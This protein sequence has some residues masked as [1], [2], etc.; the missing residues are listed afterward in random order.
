[1]ARRPLRAVLLNYL[2]PEAN[3]IFT[4]CPITKPYFCSM[5]FPCLWKNHKRATPPPVFALMLLVLPWYSWCYSFLYDADETFD[6]SRSEHAIIGYTDD[7]SMF[8][9]IGS[10]RCSWI[11]STVLNCLSVYQAFLVREWF[12]IEFKFIHV[13]FRKTA[14]SAKKQKNDDNDVLTFLSF[15]LNDSVKLLSLLR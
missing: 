8:G 5:Q 9:S 15:V 10:R 12:G 2:V 13:S 14:T 4:V 6:E 11:G 1:M 3:V 7:S